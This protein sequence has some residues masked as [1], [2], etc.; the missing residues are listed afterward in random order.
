M[1]ASSAL[2]LASLLPLHEEEELTHNLQTVERV[3]SSLV[4]LRDVPLQDP[5]QELFTDGS[6][7]VIQG[8]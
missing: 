6:S 3:S 8:E 5:D 7:F 4:H 2:N 1:K